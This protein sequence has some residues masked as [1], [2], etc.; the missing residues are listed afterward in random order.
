MKKTT[1]NKHGWGGNGTSY[2]T[3]E[4]F[5]HRNYWTLL[6]LCRKKLIF[7]ICIY[8]SS[9]GM[10]FLH[11]WFE[12]HVFLQELV[13]FNL[14]VHPLWKGYLKYLCAHHFTL[15]QGNIIPTSRYNSQA[16]TI[17]FSLIWQDKIVQIPDEFVLLRW[18]VQKGLKGCLTTF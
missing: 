12:I 2:I 11:G 4:C 7:L 14:Y 8:F 6:L 16:A 10:D 5:F 18:I 17:Y 15:G 1:C 13:F 3:N 9:S